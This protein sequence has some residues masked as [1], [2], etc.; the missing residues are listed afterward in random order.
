[1]IPEGLSNGQTFPMARGH[2]LFNATDL[3]GPGHLKGI[4]PM[5]VRGRGDIDRIDVRTEEDIVRIGGPPGNSMPKGIVRDPFRIACHDR[6]DLKFRAFHIGGH[7]FY[8][9][10]G[11]GSYHTPTQR[12]VRG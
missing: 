9:T 8:L 1:T 5:A 2:G 12:S 11:P 7:T 6:P 10:D 4:M 3:P